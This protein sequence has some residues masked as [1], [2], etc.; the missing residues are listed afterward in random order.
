MTALVCTLVT[1]LVL[2]RTIIVSINRHTGV[3]IHWDKSSSS[4]YPRSCCL[5]CGKWY[6]IRLRNRT[7]GFNFILE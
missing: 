7:F 4:G 5:S 2:T 1:F 3:I 6:G